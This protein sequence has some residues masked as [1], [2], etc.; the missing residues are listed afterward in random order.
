V[1]IVSFTYP[2]AHLPAIQNLN[3]NIPA[4]STIGIVGTTGSGKTTTVDVI[5]GL[6]HPQ[7][8]QMFVDGKPIFNDTNAGLRPAALYTLRAW[9]RALGYV[10]QHIY[11]AD[12]T[13][14]ANIAFGIPIG[15]I[16]MAA[17]TRA[18]KIAELHE[19]VNNDLAK[20]YNTPVGERGVR[21]SGGQRQRIGIAWALYHDPAVLIFDEATS[22]LDNLTEKAVMN[23]I[24][25]IRKT[26]TIFL[27][28]HRL[29][30]VEKCD[31]IFF[32]DHGCIVDQGTYDGLIESNQSFRKMAMG[33]GV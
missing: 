14:A 29:T 26:K 3:M 19:F 24:H 17:V 1:V 21:L 13:V 28:A 32:L 33:E 9:Q 8:G 31:L 16:D 25:N 10:P 22:A 30:T 7:S 23:A 2:G 18:A 11:L 27:I 5:L 6:L 12:D 20:G 4:K 15:D